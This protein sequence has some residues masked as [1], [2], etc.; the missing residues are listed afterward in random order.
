MLTGTNPV[1]SSD[2]D[3]DTYKK[4]TITQENITHV[5]PYPAKP[6]CYKEQSRAHNKGKHEINKN[7]PQKKKG[8]RT[9]SKT[10]SLEDFIM[11]YNTNSPLVLM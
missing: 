4:V 9:V 5:S 2:M 1:L 6:Q 11:F 3:Q 10:Y 7:D 8:L